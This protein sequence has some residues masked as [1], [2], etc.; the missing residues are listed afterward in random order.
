MSTYVQYL[1]GLITQRWAL[2]IYTRPTKND[3]TV[4][5]VRSYLRLRG[6]G[7]GSIYS[8]KAMRLCVVSSARVVRN[9]NVGSA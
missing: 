2:H 8:V 1:D 4:S 5:S 6:V 9:V 3:P 7:S